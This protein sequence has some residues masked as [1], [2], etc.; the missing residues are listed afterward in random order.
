MIDIYQFFKDD[1][2][3]Y[4]VSIEFMRG[5][6]LFD[7]IV[8]KVSRAALILRAPSVDGVFTMRSGFLGVCGP[9]WLEAWTCDVCPSVLSS[10]QYK[11]YT[12]VL[13]ADGVI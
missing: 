12:V 9:W 3:Y 13:Q 6:E 2:R 11:G 10:M 5:G 1:P 4:Y 8:K 7:R